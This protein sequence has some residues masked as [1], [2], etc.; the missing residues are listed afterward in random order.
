M[1]WKTPED[2]MYTQTD[3][4]IM[5]D[6]QSALVGITDYAQDQLSDIVYIELPVSGRSKSSRIMSLGSS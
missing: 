4:W 2:R 6:G 5:L 1:S 3:E